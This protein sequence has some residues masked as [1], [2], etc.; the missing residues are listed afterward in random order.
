VAIQTFGTILGVLGFVISVYNLVSAIRSRTVNPQPP[1][2]TEL[3]GYIET[4]AKSCQQ[5]RPQLNFDRHLLHTGHR[6]QIN[7]GPA[8]FETAIKRMP[9]LGRTVTSVGQRQIEL[10]NMLITN[11]T[12]SW[13]ALNNCVISDPVSLNA[14]EFS[15]K[16][17]KQ[18]RMVERFFPTYVDALTA[19]N[20]GSIWK[21]FKY[22]DHR[23]FTYKV[24][25][26]T[27]LDRAIREFETEFDRALRD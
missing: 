24:F 19:I 13:D 11:V 4:A 3:R 9:E 20:K 17:K 2:V 6:P 22:R 16:L 27:P 7:S 26:W 18:T 15:Q 12:Y 21:R 25:R 1:L 23:D 8:E 14:L 5:L 10:L